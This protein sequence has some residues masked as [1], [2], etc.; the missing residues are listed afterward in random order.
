MVRLGYEIITKEVQRNVGGLM[1]S[2][3]G[4]FVVADIVERVFGSVI[5]TMLAIM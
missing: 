5:M 1:K 2:D 3:V 4:G